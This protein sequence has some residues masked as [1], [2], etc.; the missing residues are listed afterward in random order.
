VVPTNRTQPIAAYAGGENT[1]G[2]VDAGEDLL[3]GHDERR[4]GRAPSEVSA[5][6]VVSE[7]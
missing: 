5:S 2:R 4:I 6:L 1:P 3:Y 7:R